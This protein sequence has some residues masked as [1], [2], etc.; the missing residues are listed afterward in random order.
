MRSRC[1]GAGALIGIAAACGSSED[2][3]TSKNP[4]STGGAGTGGDHAGPSGSGR[5]GRSAGG[6]SGGAAGRSAA[7]SA[8]Q[9]AAG[10]GGAAGR[11]SAGSSPGGDDGAGGDDRPAPTGGVIPPERLAPWRGHV[12]VEGG[13]PAR[14]SELDC[15]KPPYSAHADGSDTAHAIQAC[16]DGIEEGEVA[17]LPAGTYTLETTLELR[18]EKTLRGSGPGT[19]VLLFT[20]DLDADVRIRGE[21]TDGTDRGIAITAG[22]GAGSTELT[23][24]D[25]SSFAQGDRVYLSELNDASIPVTVSN[26]NG[27]CNWCGVYGS[28]GARARLELSQVTG[29]SGNRIS[30]D[31]PLFFDFSAENAPEALRASKYVERAGLESLAVVNGGSSYQAGRKPI[32]LQGAANSWV[33]NVRVEKC[34]SRCIDLWFDVFR[35]E[36][37]DSLVTGCF[38]QENSDNCYGVQIDAGSGNLVENVIFDGSANGVILVSASGNVLGYNYSHGVHRTGDMET[39]FWPDSWTHGAHSSKNLWEGNDQSALEWDYYWGSN[40][41]NLAF[42]NRF[43]GMDATV[44]YDE[45]N[46]QTVGAIL[47]YPNNNYMTAVGNVLGTAGFH[48][49]YE[50][51]TYAAVSKPIWTT[52]MSAFGTDSDKNFETLLRHLNYDSVTDGVKR[53]DDAGEP[54]CLGGDGS[55]TLPESYYL[56]SKPGFFGSATYPPIGPDVTGWSTTIPAARCYE[57]TI[58]KGKAFDGNDCY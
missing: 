13:I 46:L 8:G 17:F 18:A 36:I 48:D 21:Y 33:K 45:P 56:K 30:I 15:T 28:E 42:R 32:E 12:G 34:G 38:D 6:T 27:E 7:G 35:N 54:G 49:Q 31:P 44:A 24:A 41:H 58:A 37:R 19:T 22:L 26:D 1:V 47:T 5:A 25:A 23:L 10:S 39:W 40:S 9:A 57:Q 11:G 2:D 29:V 16:L 14:T 53:C 3:G 50:E 55:T 51:N 43:R 52:V 4:F 20:V